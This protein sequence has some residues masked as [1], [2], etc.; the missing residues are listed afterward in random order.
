MRL[1]SDTAL[2]VHSLQNGSF[3][4]Y[5]SD[6]TKPQSWTALGDVRTLTQLGELTPQGAGNRR[7]AIVTTGIGAQYNA[8]FSNGTEGSAIS[9]TFYIPQGANRLSFTYNYVSE[10]PMEYVNSQY[11]DSFVV[12]IETGGKEWYT[13][14]LATINKSSWLSVSG[15]NFT[16]GDDTTYQTGW[17][18]AEI[19][20]SALQGKVVTLRFIVYDVGDAKYDTVCL[21][22]NV[23]IE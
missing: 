9:Q 7:M 22:D 10:E 1:G 14:T 23:R 17:Q 12:K 2:L 6:S 20:V 13:Q 11:D 15:I 3:E 8:Q 21:I 5:S 19:D 16:G 4:R 18:F